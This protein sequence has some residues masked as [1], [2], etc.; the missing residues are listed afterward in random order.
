MPLPAWGRTEQIAGM[1][2][3]RKH[4]AAVRPGQ[5]VGLMVNPPRLE[6]IGQQLHSWLGGRIAAMP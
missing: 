4:H 6:G 2:S 5:E 3:A 1:A